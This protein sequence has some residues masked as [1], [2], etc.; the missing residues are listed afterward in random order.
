[1]GLPFVQCRRCIVTDV[2]ECAVN[3]GGCS[4]QANCT[5]T[6]GSF[7]CTCLEG[8]IGDGFTCSGKCNH[9]LNGSSSHMLTSTVKTSFLVREFLT[10]SLS[11]LCVRP[12][13]DIH[14]KWF[15]RRGFTHDCAFAVNSTEYNVKMKN[16]IDAHDCHSVQ[17][18][19]VGLSLPYINSTSAVR[20]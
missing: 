15:K 20:D 1:M 3:N 10:F 12:T 19:R 11:A 16:V 4:P 5:N 14:A 13:T 17:I 18:H 2:D 8:Y 9:R 6:P 7:T